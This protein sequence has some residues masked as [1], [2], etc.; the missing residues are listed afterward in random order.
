MRIWNRSALTL[1]LLACAGVDAA[2]QV[3]VNELERGA[4]I[5]FTAPALGLRRFVTR[6]DSLRGD[7]LY[8]ASNLVIPQNNFTRLDLSTGRQT[9]W[10]GASVGVW[11]GT[12]L[13]AGV[14][15]AL[16]VAG[17]L[18]DRRHSCDDCMITATQEAIAAGAATTVLGA[19]AG[20]LIGGLLHS[21]RWR[22]VELRR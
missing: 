13:G 9:F 22:R 8:M 10:E 18:Y 21:E 15:T 20:T 1:L 12:L 19:V 7:T 11:R 14:G 4:R 17:V 3:E 5:R 6:L 16:V 2:A